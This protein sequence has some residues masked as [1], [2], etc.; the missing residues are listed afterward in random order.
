VERPALTPPVAA[1]D[2]R[3]QRLRRFAHWMDAEFRVPFTPLRIGLDP[4]IGLVPGLGDA[5]GALLAGWILVE[6][7]RLRASRATLIRISGNIAADALI[8]AV[9][10]L[11]D[12]LD[13]AW[14]A[15]LRNVALLER[16]VGDPLRAS[17]SDRRFVVLVVSGVAILSLAVAVGGALL[18]A[19]LLRA[20]L[21]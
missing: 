14:K 5:A 20:I 11:G 7:V 4:I 18:G 19:A 3:L 17:S 10:V 1:P 16:H 12:A 15:N 6:A 13:V 9:P 8:G 21:P 2:A